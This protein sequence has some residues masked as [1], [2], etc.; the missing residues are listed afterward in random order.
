[1]RRLAPS[2]FMP[3][4]LVLMAAS[5]GKSAPEC[6]TVY[7]LGGKIQVDLPPGWEEMPDLHESADIK[8][9]SKSADAYLVVV[10]ER[11][12][13]LRSK[14]LED[15]S[16]FTRDALVSTMSFPQHLGPRRKRID[17]KLA[18]QYEIR[19]IGRFGSRLVELHTVLE[20]PEYFHQVVLWTSAERFKTNEPEM[21]AIVESF[22]EK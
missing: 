18:L 1:M 14:T 5:C 12:E 21:L 17:G 22:R 11:R 6:R 4:F 16:Q 20:S 2:L 19:A 3:V 10:S 13:I 9:G 7:G 15:Y 8:A